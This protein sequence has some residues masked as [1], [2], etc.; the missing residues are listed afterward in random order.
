M[1]DAEMEWV[2]AC[3]ELEAALLACERRGC[4]ISRDALAAVD[5]AMASRDPAAL[6][7]AAWA[8][9]R[10]TPAMARQSREVEAWRREF[11]TARGV[12][13]DATPWP[14]KRGR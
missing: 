14:T 2:A 13:P 1:I 6:R 3:E 4:G 10:E 5:A 7:E 11:W 9:R 8:V 12:D